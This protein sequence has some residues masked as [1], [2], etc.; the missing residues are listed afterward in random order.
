M[1]FANYLPVLFVVVLAIGFA[2]VTLGLTH[3]F[4]A[5]KYTRIKS[6]MPYE[7]GID[8]ASDARL[9]FDVKFYLVA[10]LFVVFDVEVVFFYPWAAVF[11]E[12]I[13]EGPTVLWAMLVFA[14]VLVVGL[15]YE[16]KRGALDWK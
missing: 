4:G 11:R 2:V 12:M 1:M 13:Q 14:G 15:V 3:V 8:P 10:I 6:E 7:S 5:K 9:R 16:W